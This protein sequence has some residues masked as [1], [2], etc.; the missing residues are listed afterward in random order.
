MDQSLIFYSKSYQEARER[1][2]EDSHEILHPKQVGAWQ[3]P[4][5]FDPEL[6][7]DFTYI[8]PRETPENLFILISGV[9]GVEG[10]AGSAIQ[11]QF[12]NSMLPKMNLTNSGVL[13][14]H[15]LN[16]F[17][18]K[19]HHRC[20]EN[21]VNLNRNC[22][23]TTDLYQIQNP[24]SLELSDLHLPKEPVQDVVSKLVSLRQQKD[25]RVHFGQV[26][27]EDFIKGV[28]PGQYQAPY[29][30]EFGGFKAEPQI[31][32]LTKLL[33]III[34]RFKDIFLFDLH[35]G[36]GDRGRLHLLTGDP[37]VCINP[38]LF[39]TCF[40]P[41]ID[42]H[43][44]DFTSTETEGFYETFG[45]TNDLIAQLVNENQRVCALTMEFGTLG[46]STE[47][48]IESLDSWLLKHQGT[49]Y[50]YASAEIE[51][52]IEAKNLE[53]FFPADQAWRTQILETSDQMFSRVFSRLNI[54]S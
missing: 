3:V 24:K 30:L 45:A 19:Y 43:I 39:E 2:R 28:G 53:K 18:F 42:A 9:H 20:T 31:E 25:G 10:Y 12:I 54:L 52:K 46:H 1:F 38:S 4:S 47:K 11:L 49:F 16:P 5:R 27:M 15:S 48:Q 14:V 23:V 36:L 32:E 7:V 40:A 33:K 44:Y 17:G 29:G 37:K 6:F 34:P 21:H 22:S 8:A 13:L 50:G 51:A 41:Q 35:T 26:S